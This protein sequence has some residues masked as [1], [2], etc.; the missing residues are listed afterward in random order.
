VLYKVVQRAEPRTPVDYRGMVPRAE[1]SLA[2]P[3]VLQK[4]SSSLGLRFAGV[5]AFFGLVGWVPRE[6]WVTEDG[7]VRVSARRQKG[8]VIEG[9]MSSYFLSTTFD[10]GSVILTWSKS[11]PPTA[12]SERVESIGGSGDLTADLAKHRAA[13]GRR[14]AANPDLRPIPAVTVDDC[15]LLSVHHDRFANSDGALAAIVQVRVVGWGGLAALLAAAIWVLRWFA[16]HA[17]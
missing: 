7:D 12:S 2:S 3:D 11:P 13:V 6:C 14:L 17:L 10:D 1:G 15:V 8:G 4:A 5:Y 16:A 9:A